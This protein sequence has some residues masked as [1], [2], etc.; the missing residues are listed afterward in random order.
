M[1]HAGL[2]GIGR[3]QHL[4][5]EQDA[6][7]KILANDAH[8]FDQRLGQHLVGHPAALEQD[9][10]A[11][12]DLFLQPVIEIVVHLLHQLIV[13]KLGKDDLVVGHFLPA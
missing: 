10:R 9:P 13:G 7:A 8:A 1:T 4:G 6:V 2:H 5:N 3:Q 11:F 12:L